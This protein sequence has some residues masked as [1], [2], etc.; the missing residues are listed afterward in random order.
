[1]PTKLSRVASPLVGH[2]P[3]DCTRA[4]V[5]I[6]MVTGA[7]DCAK[8][9]EAATQI[10][11]TSWRQKPADWVTAPWIEGRWADTRLVDAD[12]HAAG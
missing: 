1:V 7:E 9:A 6:D 2:H 10:A 8:D 5:G 3:G 4:E 12:K 11:N